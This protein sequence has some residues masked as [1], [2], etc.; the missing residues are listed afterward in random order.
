MV[1]IVSKCLFCTILFSFVFADAKAVE[2]QRPPAMTFLVTN[3]QGYKEYKNEKD[4]S[5]LIEITA[6]AFTIGSDDTVNLDAYYIGKY[7][8]TN[9]QY[10]NFCDST[11]RSYPEDPNFDGM[12]DYV[13]NYPDYPVVNVSWDD[14]AA[15]C[16][17]AGLR[18]PTEAEWERSARGTDG[19]EYPWGNDEPDA[20]GLYRANWGEGEDHTVWKKDGYEYTAPVGCYERG[21]SL[22]GCYDMAGNVWEWCSDWYDEN[23]YDTSPEQNPQGPS[24]G[25]DRVDRGGSWQSNPGPLRST[26]RAWDKPAYRNYDLGFR[27]ASFR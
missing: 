5:T 14:A 8:V 26:N 7:E 6:G 12:P 9:K 10:K 25:T 20:D 15:Y 3:D 22:C 2:N 19:R 13:T 11:G 1:L 18:L 23:Y 27:V 21:R 4:G 17:W 24:S 16:D